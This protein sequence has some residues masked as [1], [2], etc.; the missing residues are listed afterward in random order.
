MTTIPE[1][2]QATLYKTA[3]GQTVD[4]IAPEGAYVETY[5]EV[6]DA[7]QQAAYGAILQEVKAILKELLELE[8]EVLAPI[9]KA[10]KMVRDLFRARLYPL[11]KAE[12]DIKS[13]MGLYQRK[14]LAEAK[15]KEAAERKRVEEERIAIEAMAAANNLKPDEADDLLDA[16]SHAPTQR[17][18][19]K[20]PAGTSFRQ[21]Y[22]AEVTD[23]ME[24]LRGII[25]GQV[26]IT[27]VR[28]DATA[29]NQWARAT[30]G[31]TQMRGVKVI[32]DTTVVS[33]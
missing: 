11:E 15:A 9:T 14:Q 19:T 31:L 5:G 16:L 13:E 1:Y 28:P 21:T 10:E 30:K 12:R 17:F 6:T 33:R 32:Q 22:H 3:L 8:A 25:A 4:K 24:L 23:M 29:L 2:F 27:M 26:P 20:A 7:E 18:E